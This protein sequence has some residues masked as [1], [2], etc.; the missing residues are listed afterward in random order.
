MPMSKAFDPE[1]ADGLGRDGVY[2]GACYNYLLFVAAMAFH[3][4][5][6]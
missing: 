2:S 5:L 1:V 4:S 3:L 6:S